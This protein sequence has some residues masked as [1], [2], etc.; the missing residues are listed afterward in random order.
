LIWQN[1]TTGERRVWLMNGTAFSSEVSYGTV[2]L[3]WQ[4]VGAADYN[5]DGHVDIVWQNTITGE[6]GIWLMNGTTLSGYVS[7]GI[8]STDWKIAN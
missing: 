4:I 1:I 3:D 2:G 5:V 7:L 8:Q 6:S